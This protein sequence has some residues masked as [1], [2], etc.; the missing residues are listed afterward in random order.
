MDIVYR[1]C[2]GLD[3]H[4]KTAVACLIRRP[5]DGPPSREIRTFGTT[6]EE[7][8]AL[9]PWLRAAGCEAVAMESTGV[10][11]KP[12]YNL[13]EEHFPLLVVNAAH[14]KAVP[15]RKTDVKDAEWIA[16]LLQHGLLRA[17]F[18]PK[19]AQREL[20][21]LT[22]TGTTLIDERTAAVNRLQAVLEDA[23]IKLAS[24]ATDITG[25]SGRAML[26]A[27]L[28]GTSD[29]AEMA[30]LA[31]GK[32][33]QKRAQL[34]RALTGRLSAHHRLLIGLHLERIDFLDEQRPEGT[35]RLSAE[36]AERLR[37][38]AAELDRLDTIPGIDRR[39]AA[40]LAAEM[41]LVMAQFPSAGHLAS[42]AGVAPG[43]NES[44]GKQTG[45]K[46]PKGNKWIRR[47]LIEA[48]NGAART[49]NCYLGAQY[50]RLKA[51]H[52][53]QKAIVAVGH[54]ILTIAYHLLS[55]QTTDTDLG[56]TYLDERRR[57]RA[58]Q[59]AVDQL[60]ALGYEVTLTLKATA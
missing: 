31:K 9:G 38:F 21:A 23:N 33:R 29:P 11:W 48:G 51:R 13:L 47:A 3:V 55:R 56:P 60:Q 44:A 54:S 14:I 53:H 16:E 27:L 45:G 8:L 24:V 12:L 22:R 37:P 30:E 49:K 57:A 28:E 59:R 6:T 7:I 39:T 2:C 18:V 15:G 1:V 34:E 4:K 58:Q 35:R 32:L 19:R 43:N 20:R 50:R 42:W 25:V 40:V 17:S 26:A 46:P 36:I 5:A 52:G 41:G 10:Y